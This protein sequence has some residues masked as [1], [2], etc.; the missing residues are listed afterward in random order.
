M[1]NL[2]KKQVTA[3]YVLV[4]IVLVC[5]IGAIIVVV[6]GGDKGGEVKN[7]AKTVAT[8]EAENADAGKDDIDANV[9]S[10]DEIKDGDEAPEAGDIVGSSDIDSLMSELVPMMGLAKTVDL[11]ASKVAYYY[12][13]DESDFNNAKGVI[14]DVALAD[15]LVIIEAKD[16]SG[17]DKIKAGAEGR[18]SSQKSSFQD[19][20]PEQFK[21]LDGA[22]IVTS[23]NYVMYVV[24]DNA[25]K[26]VDKFNEKLN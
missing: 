16:A 26:I 9:K 17:V 12:E 13:L 11:D 20:I 25:D 22:K 18:L 14:G 7:T 10:N 24:S 1:N 6:R 23:G 3:L 19:Y 5:L 8:T 15:E 2:S 4:G 21:R